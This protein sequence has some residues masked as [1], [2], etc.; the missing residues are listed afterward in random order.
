MK[1]VFYLFFI[2]TLGFD[3]FARIPDSRTLI[4]DSGALFEFHSLGE[5]FPTPYIVKIND[6]EVRGDLRANELNTID[7]YNGEGFISLHLDDEVYTVTYQSSGEDVAVVEEGCLV[8]AQQNNLSHNIQET[9]LSSKTY[10][11][12]QSI[13]AQRRPAPSY[14]SLNELYWNSPRPNFNSVK[15]SWIAIMSRSRPG[16]S[17]Y[18]QNNFANIETS[19]GIENYDGSKFFSLDFFDVDSEFKSD[20][21]VNLLNIGNNDA[22]QGPFGVTFDETSMNFSYCAFKGNKPR[23]SARFLLFC[24]STA[25]DKILCR[26]SPRGAFNHDTDYGRFLG[27]TMA[28]IGFRKLA[29]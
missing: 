1:S 22:D 28:F 6:T 18:S 15:G 5:I 4:C 17:L 21:L 23:C 11:E 7:F 16:L 26:I 12:I 25:P 9:A 19:W 20:N 27:R 2:F 24:R 3:A 10:D 13:N 8:E 14:Q 29:Q